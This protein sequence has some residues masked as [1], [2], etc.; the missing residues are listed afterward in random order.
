MM[1]AYVDDRIGWRDLCSP[2]ALLWAVALLHLVTV[3]PLA[4]EHLLS[5]RPSD[6]LR[7]ALVVGGALVIAVLARRLL[8]EAI[9][10]LWLGRRLQRALRPLLTRRVRLW[11]TAHDL[12]VQHDRDADGARHAAR[13]NRIA[14]ARPQCATWMGDRNAALETRVRTEYGLDLPSAWPRLWMLLPETTRHDLRTALLTWRDATAWAAWATLFVPLAFE[15]W[16]LAPLS[17]LGWLWAVRSARYAVETLTDL[18][19]AAVDLY[20]PRLVAQLGIA[21]DMDV[22]EPSTGRRV[23]IRLRKGG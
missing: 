12:A 23:N 9:A 14:L 4:G 3:R 5:G 10:A 19:E 8:A 7:A 18:T 20:A 17:A 2:P 11:E 1:W 16:P 6:C 13:R 21:T 15:W 22:V